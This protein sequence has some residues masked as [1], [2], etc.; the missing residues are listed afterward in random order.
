MNDEWGMMNKSP[1]RSIKKR[2]CFYTGNN[3]KKDR[4]EE[5]RLM[6]MK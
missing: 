1:K 4:K 2:D 5:F 6:K 3:R